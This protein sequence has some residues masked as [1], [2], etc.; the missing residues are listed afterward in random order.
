MRA[1]GELVR[2]LDRALCGREFEP[3][4]DDPR[5]PPAGEE[6]TLGVQA[7]IVAEPRAWPS[8]QLELTDLVRPIL[9][10]DIPGEVFEFFDRVLDIRYA[11]CPSVRGPDIDGIFHLDG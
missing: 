3:S 9:I 5:V 6:L 11:A 10:R 4:H 1:R 2:A 7:V 8:V